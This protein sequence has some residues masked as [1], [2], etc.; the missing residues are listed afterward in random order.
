MMQSR[1]TVSSSHLSSS[2]YVI[3]YGS[4]DRYSMLHEKLNNAVRAYDRLLEQRVA[5][6]Y[7]RVSNTSQQ[8]GAP[9]PVYNT[10]TAP[11]Q[12]PVYPQ[13]LYPGMQHS[14]GEISYPGHQSSLYQPPIA[15]SP[16]PTTLSPTAPSYGNPLSGMHPSTTIP[17]QDPA[18]S[19][20]QPEQRHIPQTVSAVGD[21]HHASYHYDN[22]LG[23]WV[24]TNVSQQMQP[25][26]PPAPQQVNFPP[27]PTHIPQQQQQQQAARPQVE[28]ASLIEL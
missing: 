19:A 24:M 2:A 16:R 25:P 27:A 26:P 22:Q 11:Q 18:P 12:Y 15:T 9:Q 8:H 4:T 7:Q 21:N 28:E 23:Q 17:T 1:D 5:S 14:N 3:N 10:A 6:S 20:D 13:S